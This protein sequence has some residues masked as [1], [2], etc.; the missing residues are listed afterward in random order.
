MVIRIDRTYG[1]FRGKFMEETSFFEVSKILSKEILHLEDLVKGDIL[2]EGMTLIQGAFS[3]L[4]ADTTLSVPRNMNKI[5][6]L[7]EE[8]Y[9]PNND[10]E[11]DNRGSIPVAM[12][13]QTCDHNK[14]YESIIVSG[15]FNIFLMENGK[16]FDKEIRNFAIEDYY[17]KETDENIH[18]YLKNTLEFLENNHDFTEYILEHL[19]FSDRIVSSMKFMINR[20]FKCMYEIAFFNDETGKIFTS[21]LLS[22]ERLQKIIIRF[23]GT[24]EQIAKSFEERVE[25]LEKW[26]NRK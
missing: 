11:N 19:G 5:V 24:A 3:S 2:P 21:E 23:N 16:T 8:Y 25:E 1:D 15:N 18:S 13:L 17:L 26:E 14:R 22:K 7:I 9:D 4:E 20:N 10:R 12:R 6:N